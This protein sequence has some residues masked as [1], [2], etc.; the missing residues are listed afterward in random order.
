MRMAGEETEVGIILKEERVFDHSFFPVL[1]RVVRD[2]NGTEREQL[3]WD[4][5][6]KSFVVAVACTEDKHFV[7]IREPKYGQ[8]RKLL[9]C[10]AGA[11]KRGE[12][13]KEAANREFR[14]E[15]GYQADNWIVLRHT[16]LIDFPD[17]IDGGEH[18][19]FMGFNAVRITDPEPGRELI[20]VSLE[21]I[22]KILDD[23]GSLKLEI[24]MS[25]VA[26]SSALRHMS[27]L[28]L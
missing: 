4:R 27:T 15:T 14:E 25:Y 18:Y 26:I 13:P 1:R 5:F 22:Q 7:L 23:Q 12:K 19:I 11:I 6:G 17:K 8:M 10:P 20:L 24:A 3:L 9:T 16:P 28:R 21:G 2:S